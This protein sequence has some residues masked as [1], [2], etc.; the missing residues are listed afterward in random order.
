MQNIWMKQVSMKKLDDIQRNIIAREMENSWV[1]KEN[2]S[3]M[4]WINLKVRKLKDEKNPVKIV[5]HWK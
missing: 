1:T 3:Q 2:I 5:A 4:V